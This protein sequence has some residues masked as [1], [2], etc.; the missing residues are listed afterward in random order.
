MA[1][2]MG[3]DGIGMIETLVDAGADINMMNHKKK[4]P[5]HMA[6]LNQSKKQVCMSLCVHVYLYVHFSLSCTLTLNPPSLP[7]DK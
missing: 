5:L 4:T 2:E 7:S 6:C 3:D 1:M